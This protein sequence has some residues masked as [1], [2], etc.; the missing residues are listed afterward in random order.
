MQD[1]IFENIKSVLS[2]IDRKDYPEIHRFLKSI[3]QKNE[4]ALSEYD[5]A[6][7]LLKL[8]S[9]KELPQY[10]IDLISSLFDSSDAACIRSVED[11][12]FQ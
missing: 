10:L 6:I 11:G 9:K 4:Q 5:V 8:D 12:I 1:D 2:I 3:V 7:N